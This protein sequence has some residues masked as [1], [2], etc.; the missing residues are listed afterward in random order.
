MSNNPRMGQE[1]E[2]SGMRRFPIYGGRF[3][4]TWA[5]NEV[6]VTLTLLEFLDSKYPQNL[7]GFFFDEE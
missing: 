2:I 4:V 3:V 6:A 7:R 5:I 1:D